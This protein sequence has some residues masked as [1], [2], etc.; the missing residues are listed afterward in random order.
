[1]ISF[2]WQRNQPLQLIALKPNIAELIITQAAQL[3]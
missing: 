1:M 3:Q 2:Q